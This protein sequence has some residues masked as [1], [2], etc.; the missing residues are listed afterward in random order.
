MAKARPIDNLTPDLLFVTA[1]ALTV[2]VRADELFGHA[3][4]VLDTD[5]IDR[6]HDMRVATRRLRAVLDLYA[7]CFPEPELKR[8]IRGVKALADGLGARR[9]PDVQLR[10]LAAFAAALGPEDAAGVEVF[11]DRLRTE[12]QEGNATLALALEAATAD[13]LQG[14]LAALVAA[15]MPDE[16][17]A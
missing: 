14:Q 16:V 2:A 1:A 6:V 10:D 17:T 11:A 4:G 5:D 7:P 9:D 12:Q 15:A 3:D 13:D 8:A